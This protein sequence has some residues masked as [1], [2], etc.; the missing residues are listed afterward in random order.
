MP[1]CWVWIHRKGT[2]GSFFIS[3]SPVSKISGKGLERGEKVKG[4]LLPPQGKIRNYYLA[5]WWITFCDH[6]ISNQ[7]TFS[8][9]LPWHA[10]M[11]STTIKATRHGSTPKMRKMGRLIKQSKCQFSHQSIQKRD[12][13]DLQIHAKHQCQKGYQWRLVTLSGSRL[14]DIFWTL[15]WNAY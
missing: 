5:L 3:T 7:A 8:T 2:R 15:E 12:K 6:I 10:K 1:Q 11:K 4:L 9:N 14:P 13:Q